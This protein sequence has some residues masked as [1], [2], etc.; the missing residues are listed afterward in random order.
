MYEDRWVDAETAAQLGIQPNEDPGASLPRLTYG[1]NN[2]NQQTSTYWLRDGRYI[3]LKNVDIGYTLPKA[4]V[5][6]LHLNNVRVY[7]TGQN[8]LTW[9]KFDTWDPE[10]T[11]PRGEQYPLTKAVTL[12]LTVNL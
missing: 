6:S 7:I 9:S 3:R 5:N 1:A 10:T 2:N 11:D 4:F 8:L 12:G